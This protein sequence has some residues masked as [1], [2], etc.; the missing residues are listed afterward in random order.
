M[1]LPQPGINQNRQHQSPAWSASESIGPLT[2]AETTQRQLSPRAHPCI[3]GSFQTPTLEHSSHPAGSGAGLEG[4]SRNSTLL[5]LRAVLPA[6]VCERA[7]Y[8]WSV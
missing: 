8:I 1:G 5:K 3:G 4:L 6:Y 2:G 7:C